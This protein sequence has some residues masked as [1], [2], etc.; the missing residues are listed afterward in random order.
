MSAKTCFK[1]SSQHHICTSY[2]G[3]IEQQ[4]QKKQ[5]MQTQPTKDLA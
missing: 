1:D 2:D 4:Y 3:E 5:A